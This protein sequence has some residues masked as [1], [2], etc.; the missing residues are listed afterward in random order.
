M[1][2]SRRVSRTRKAKLIL[3]GSEGTSDLEVTAQ[4]PQRQLD[5]DQPK[6]HNVVNKSEGDDSACDQNHGEVKQKRRTKKT[7]TE[8]PEDVGATHGSPTEITTPVKKKGKLAN[9]PDM[10]IDVLYE[11]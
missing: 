7:K 6:T 4:L 5:D 11:V 10:P 8:Q 1:P 9:L 3:A 2:A